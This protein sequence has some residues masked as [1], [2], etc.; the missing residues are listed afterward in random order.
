R[1]SEV[2]DER[3]GDRIDCA[4]DRLDGG[5]GRGDDEEVDTLG[6]APQ[7]VSP[8]ERRLDAPAH[9][10]KG[11]RDRRAGSTGADH[12]DCVHT[13]LPSTF[14]PRTGAVRTPRDY[15]PG[16]RIPAPTPPSLRAAGRGPGRRG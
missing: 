13:D 11:A 8:T 15:P 7:I 2:G 12:P 10:G 1:P 4:G 6:G 14:R 3:G 16:A 5:V 9:R